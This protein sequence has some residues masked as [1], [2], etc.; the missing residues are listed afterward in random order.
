MTA[1]SDNKGILVI[2]DEQHLLDSL[3][4]TLESAGFEHVRTC[5]D[6]RE[7]LVLLSRQEYGAILLDIFMP[8]LSGETILGE[9]C[10]EYPHTPVIMVSGINELETA[11]R[12]IKNGA[13]DYLVKPVEAERLITTVR[14]GLKHGALL[15]ENESLRRKIFSHKLQHPE[16]FTGII[17]R[18]ESMNNI[19]NYIE[20]IAPA[21]DPVLITGETGTGKELIARSLHLASG[22]SGKFV[23]VN[24]AGLDDYV[25][26]DTL[27]GH[28][29]GAFTDARQARSGL[30]GQADEGT[31]FLDEI[32][33][34]A[35]ASQ[36][37][38]LKLIQAGEYYPLGSDKLNRSSA[39]IVAATN[40]DLKAKQKQ[41]SFR[42]D[43]FYR[44][45]TY[46]VH[47]PPLRNRREDIPA[48]A[49]HFLAEASKELNITLPKLSSKL[50]CLLQ[51]YKYPGNIRELRAMLFDGLA[52]GGAGGLEKKLSAQAGACDYP[53]SGNHKS[54]Q[55]SPG[56]MFFPH[57]LP[58]LEEVSRKL[59]DEAMDRARG[60]RTLAAKMLGV[61]RQ[62][63]HRR[64]KETE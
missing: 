32:G 43:L 33:D 58:S 50:S 48:L 56:G 6:S 12:C 64:L 41:G 63:L 25:F 62:T 34:L 17:T 13:F 22:R 3:S 46:H 24:V 20:V 60:N 54:P 40:Q 30:V 57:P 23:E 52:R 38:L 28:V 14:R 59:I 37:K 26:A 39:R 7:A 35:P 49:E 55:V 45:G 19:F 9:I 16:A 53:P 44:L 2:D 18:C 10:A 27:F 21:L 11:V 42:K 15:R 8:H 29:P 36:V 51:N 4:L 1:A 5:S 47:L 31:L 61:S